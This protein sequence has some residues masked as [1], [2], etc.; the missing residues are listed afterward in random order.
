MIARRTC[1]TGNWPVPLLPSGSGGV[2]GV[3]LRRT[4]LSAAGNSIHSI[5][6]LRE[7]PFCHRGLNTRCPAH[8]LKARATESKIITLTPHQPLSFYAPGPP[9]RQLGILNFT[10]NLRDLCTVPLGCEPL[11][12]GASG[13]RLL[14]NNNGKRSPAN[15]SRPDGLR[16]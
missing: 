4:R 15:R 2:R 7:A 16:A 11:G 5:S 9:P 1:G 3:S 13:I 8:R 14:S 6:S 12:S 10:R